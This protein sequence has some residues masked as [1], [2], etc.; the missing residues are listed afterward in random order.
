MHKTYARAVR[1][2]PN[3]GHMTELYL[4]VPSR[5]RPPAS[6]I[7]TSLTPG[8]AWDQL[9]TSDDTPTP[10]EQR[11]VQ[12]LGGMKAYLHQGCRSRER[13]GIPV[14]R[15]PFAHDKRRWSITPYL[16]QAGT[17]FTQKTADFSLLLPDGPALE[18]R[19][20]FDNSASYTRWSM[21]S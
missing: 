15:W 13:R 21:L 4:Q 1:Y 8:L 17:D 7:L 18:R 20:S 5:Q 16:F 19:Q 2:G 12:T 6:C 9:I 14:D 10:A 3:H 11:T